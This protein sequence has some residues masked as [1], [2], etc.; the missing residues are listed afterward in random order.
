MLRINNGSFDNEKLDKK[1]E[2]YLSEKQR[3]KCSVNPSYE[4]ELSQYA[5][6][7]NS[8]SFYC[9]CST[10][11]PKLTLR[12]RKNKGYILAHNPGESC[13]HLTSCPHAE[14]QDEASS[15]VK[16]SHS[17]RLIDLVLFAGAFNVLF[18]PFDKSSP[19]F[20]RWDPL[21]LKLE[22][23]A[24]VLKGNVSAGY[25]QVKLFDKA[26]PPAF[27][28]DVTSGEKT[29]NDHVLHYG[30]V[31]DNGPFLTVH[32][33]TGDEQVRKSALPIASMTNPIVV[34]SEFERHV[35]FKLISKI[36]DDMRIHSSYECQLSGLPFNAI[37]IRKKSSQTVI[38]LLFNIKSE[39]WLKKLES[40]MPYTRIINLSSPNDID[41]MTPE[42][43]LNKF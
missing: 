40:E 20:K 22:S 7:S 14:T 41:D 4:R 21:I 31:K 26:N 10:V 6:K 37:S 13:L 25:Q 12:S 9:G 27:W 24:S 23:K 3:N 15:S 1:L 2:T 33:K 28:L 18:K 11:R 5:S 17:E 8:P 30:S 29:L 16:F 38:Y 43:I 39:S 36:Q 19:L 32:C 35:V 42:Q 34:Y